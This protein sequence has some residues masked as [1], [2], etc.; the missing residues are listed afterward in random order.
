MMT[1]GIMAA[2][3]VGCCTRIVCS[4]DDYEI[5]TV[6]LNCGIEVDRRPAVLATDSAAVA[7]VAREFLK[8]QFVLPEIL[9]L[10][11]PTSPFLQPE[12]LSRLVE[13]M[14]AHPEC[15]SGQTITEVGHNFH[16]WNQRIYETGEVHFKFAKERK[17]AYNKQSKPKL[18][19]FGNLVAVRP[20]ALIE[21]FDFFAEPS[22][23]VEIKWPYNLD[24]DGPTDLHIAE[25]LLQA[26]IVG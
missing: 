14:I 6:A 12:H 1:W 22:V 23:G 18:F 21:G 26:G 16:A 15:N 7:D 5:A 24:V 20:R 19:T 3:S 13:R 10:V 25:L 9:I 4:T 17:T 2:K 11:Q 8:R